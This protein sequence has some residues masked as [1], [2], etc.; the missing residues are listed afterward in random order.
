METTLV[1]GTLGGLAGVEVGSGNV[2]ARPEH[3]GRLSV[4]LA[5]PDETSV[6]VAVG[7]SIVVA[8]RRCTLTAIERR[9]GGRHRLT[10]EVEGE[11]DE[12][13]VGEAVG[14]AESPPGAAETRVVGRGSGVTATVLRE[15]TDQILGLLGV[16]LRGGVEWERSDREEWLEIDRAPV[17]PNTTTTWTMRI[18]E[19]EGATSDVS[20]TVRSETVRWNPHEVHRISTYGHWTNGQE[21]IHVSVEQMTGEVRVSGSDRVVREVVALLGVEVPR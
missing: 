20:A 8:G 9:E 13:A 21:R 10:F 17:G 6:V 2:W 16:P 4:L 15:R 1:A 7:E 14:R 11:E 19:V 5:L 3:D 12:G 18:D